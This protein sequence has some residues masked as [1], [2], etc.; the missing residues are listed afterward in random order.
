MGDQGPTFSLFFF[1]KESAV[2]QVGGR[3]REKQS[4]YF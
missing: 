2:A 3:Q 1:E 4:P